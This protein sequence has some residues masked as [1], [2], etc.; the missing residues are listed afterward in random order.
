MTERRED[1]GE[2][3]LRGN[4]LAFRRAKSPSIVDEPITSKV[5]HFFGKTLVRFRKKE[6]ALK[7]NA[8]VLEPLF[9]SEKSR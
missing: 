8:S 3:S 2:G 7:K 9:F 5:Y 1:E 4:K 6:N